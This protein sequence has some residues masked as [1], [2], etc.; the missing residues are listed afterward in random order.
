MRTTTAAATVPHTPDCLAPR[1]SVDM[2]VAIFPQDR[3][4]RRAVG[5]SYFLQLGHG[6]HEG[7]GTA[8]VVAQHSHHQSVCRIPGSEHLLER[9]EIIATVRLHIKM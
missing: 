1:N 8:E 3:P 6:L 9:S 7:G 2:R 5:T 4:F